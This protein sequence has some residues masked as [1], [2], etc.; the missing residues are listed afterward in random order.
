MLQAEY[1]LDGEKLR[2]LDERIEYLEQASQRVGRI[3]WVQIFAGQLVG[4]VMRAVLPG[5]AIGQ[6]LRFLAQ[7]VGHLFGGGGVLELPGP[8]YPG[9]Q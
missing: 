1:K 2:D 3:D 5:D 8:S 7:S 9:Q 6:C 4:L